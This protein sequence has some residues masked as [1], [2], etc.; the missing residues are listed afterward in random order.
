MVIFAIDDS[1]KGLIAAA[2]H[3]SGADEAGV[4]VISKLRNHNKVF[5]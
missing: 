2:F 4:D 3:F 5:D 1:M